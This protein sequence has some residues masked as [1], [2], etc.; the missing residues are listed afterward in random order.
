MTLDLR[1]LALGLSF[2]FLWSSAFTS[3]TIIV[4]YAPPFATLALRFAISGLLALAIG[5][6]MGQR[7]TLDRSTI[8]AIIGFGIL[9]NIVYLGFNF[10][11]MQSIEASVAVIVAST[12]PLLVALAS[13]VIFRERLR[14]LAVIGLILGIAGVVLI[15]VPRVQAGIDPVGV[16]LCVVGVLALTGATLLVRGASS[17]GNVMMVVGLQMLVGGAGLLVLSVFVE[18]WEV[19]F[20]WQL[21]AAFT[22]TTLFPGLLATIIWFQLIARV[23]ATR[24]ATFHFLNPFI[25]VSIAALVLGE[26]LVLRDLVGVVIIMVG[27]YAVQSARASAPRP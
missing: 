2:V 24:A 25:G 8:K 13:W 12:L 3:A 4:T 15:M 10:V 22:Y 16:M 23:G 5:W 7:F 18:T 1:A 27:I 21:V 17:S 11:A 9:Q 26:V 14:P 6:A 20:T 19:S